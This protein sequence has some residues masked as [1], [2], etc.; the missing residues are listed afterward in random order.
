M[1]HSTLALLTGGCLFASAAHGVVGIHVSG[2]TLREADG[3]TAFDD[4]GLLQLINLGVDGIPN[5]VREGAWVTGDDVLVDLP[6]GS[7]EFASSG[8]FDLWETSGDPGQLFRVFSFPV[9]PGVIEEGDLL[10]LRW[11]PGYTA[12]DFHGGATPVEGDFF[13]EGRLGAAVNDPVNNTGWIVPDESVPLTIFDPLISPDLA[14]AYS[15]TPTP[16]FDGV[17]D[18][19]VEAIPEPSAAAGVLG[20]VAIALTGLR[21]RGSRRWVASAS[22]NPFAAA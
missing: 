6:F 12:A 8:G 18:L 9:T 16:G 1:R 5:P 7:S 21:R 17:P 2:G 14:I 22:R 3:S 13:G 11:W 15:L 4:E 20:L 19:M 10:M